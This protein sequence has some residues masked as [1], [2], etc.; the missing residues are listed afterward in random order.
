[1]CRYFVLTKKSLTYYKAKGEKDSKGSIKL[2]DIREVQTHPAKRNG[3]GTRFDIKVRGFGTCPLT[4]LANPKE[5]DFSLKTPFY[6]SIRLS[7]FLLFSSLS[8][9]ALFSPPFSSAF[10]FSSLFFSYFILHFHVCAE[11]RVYALDAPNEAVCREWVTHI[12]TSVR[13]I[14]DKNNG[15]EYDVKKAQIKVFIIIIFIP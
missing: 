13:A 5:I 6:W 14:V 12:L 1:M 7:S 2:V 11:A 9:P 10:Y 3:E 8:L 4:M 15:A